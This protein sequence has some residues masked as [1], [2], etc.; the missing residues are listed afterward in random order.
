M[1]VRKSRNGNMKYSE[2]L[3]PW[4]TPLSWVTEKEDMPQTHNLLVIPK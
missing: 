1:E 3:E 4:D 2:K